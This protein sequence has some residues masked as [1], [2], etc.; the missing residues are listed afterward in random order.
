M[1]ASWVA[2]LTELDK[3]QGSE[4]KMNFRSEV[5]E[6]CAKKSGWHSTTLVLFVGEERCS[7]FLTNRARADDT[8]NRAARQGIRQRKARAGASPR[9]GECSTARAVGRFSTAPPSNEVFGYGHSTCNSSWADRKNLLHSNFQRDKE[10]AVAVRGGLTASAFQAVL[11]SRVCREEW[12]FDSAWALGLKWLRMRE[13]PRVASKAFGR[14]W[15][16]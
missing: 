14:C 11:G 5:A 9:C 13:T 8:V 6:R 4:G 10:T 3:H 7:M 2:R 1:F 16:Y 12:G 15:R